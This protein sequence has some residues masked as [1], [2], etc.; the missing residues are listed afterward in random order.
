MLAVTDSLSEDAVYDITKAIFD[1]AESISHSK[2][3]FI[4]AETGVEGIGIDFHP[5]AEKYF[6][7][8]GVLE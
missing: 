6:K 7:E 3:E 8:I 4:T 2:A 1:N 5:G